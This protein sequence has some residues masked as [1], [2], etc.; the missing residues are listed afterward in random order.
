MIIF[1]SSEVQRQQEALLQLQRHVRK[2]CLGELK[3]RKR[4]VEHL[5]RNCI[6][7][8]G[9]QAVPRCP[10]GAE[11]NAESR[12][13]EAGERAAQTSRVRKHRVRWQ[14]DVLEYQL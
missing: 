12:L 8:G 5:P 7:D 14:V 3:R 1:K 9:L 13:V 10:E 11:D 6:V 4:A 2:L